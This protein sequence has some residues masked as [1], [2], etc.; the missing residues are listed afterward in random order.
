MKNQ[1]F[2]VLGTTFFWACPIAYG[3]APTPTDTLTTSL[4]KPYT[5]QSPKELVGSGSRQIPGAYLVMPDLTA[6]QQLATLPN[7]RHIAFNLPISRTQSL[8]LIIHEIAV[9]TP[10]FRIG[11][12]S[13]RTIPLPALKFYTGKVAGD[14]SSTVALSISDEGLEGLIYGKDYSY[15]L[16]RMKPARLNS[17]HVVY[18][19]QELPNPVGFDCKG[20]EV[21][22]STALPPQ[23]GTTGRKMTT[24]DCRGVSIY[25]EADY[26]LYL[27]WGSDVS[28]IATKILSA[29]ANVVILYAKEDI[30]IELGE[31]KIWDTPDPYVQADTPND[32][33]SQFKSHWNTNR[34]SFNGDIAHLLSTRINQGGVAY[35][36]VSRRN[37]VTTVNDISAVFSDQASRSYAFS[38]STGFYDPAL[39]STY[40][41]NVY[42]IAHELGHNFGLPHTHSCLWA[43]GPIDD[44][45]PV[46][47]GTCPPGP[48]P[49][50]GGTIMSYCPN[51]ANGFGP[52][53]SAKLKYELLAAQNLTNTG[54]NPVQITPAAVTANRGQ[55]TT[56]DVANCPR[57]VLWSDGIFSGNSRTILPTHSTTYYAS[58]LAN[59]CLSA[60]AKTTLHARCAEPAACSILSPRSLSTLYG[61]ATFSFNTLL[62][63]APND[64][65]TNIGASYED[66][67]CT[68]HSLVKA[69]ESYPFTLS[70]TLGS[71]LFA[72]I[73]ID[74]NGNGEFDPAN[75][76]V[77]DGPSLSQH[78]GTI[79]IPSTALRGTP[80]RLRVM[81]N[82]ILIP[83]ACS[84]P[85][86]LST[87][88]GKVNDYVITITDRTC[89]PNFRESVKSGYWDDPLVWSCG[90]LP[91]PLDQV[92]I[93]AG[94]YVTLP[95]GSTGYAGSIDLH[96]VIQ[97]GQNST[98]RIIDP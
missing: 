71:S 77:Y 44:C 33:L 68:Q 82:P 17:L 6:I 23:G 13:G 42:L 96:G 89:P 94:H 3:Q 5:N 76:L 52:Q 54:V 86:T 80:L 73:Y 62:T 84:L 19:T 39:T 88:P 70:G 24:S 66:F 36:G 98:L 51:L 67:T 72:K 46:E 58:C 63:N 25:L 81:V 60:P 87:K 48:T 28:Y 69:G 27:D 79:T 45:G 55:Y 85:S 14:A 2:V 38:A 37:I 4:I 12:S 41:F 97:P 22:L 59:G 43:G 34:N 35:Y 92:K 10:D 49:A 91:T 64:V 61:I 8:R 65:P 50:S 21:P 74:Y 7:Q 83:D 18:R 47:D 32:L 16:G 29:F 95:T 20:V 75:E 11:T 9:V 26:Q 31:L 93:N 78:S 1:L 15:T 53:P 90:T 56:F 30:R 57:T 40:S